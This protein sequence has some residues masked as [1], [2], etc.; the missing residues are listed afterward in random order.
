MMQSRNY[1]ID[2]LRL[3]LM[4]MVCLL[5]VLGQGGILVASKEGTLNYY[6]FWF[7]EIFAYCAVDGFALIS[8]YTANNKK[9]K[10]EKIV[11]MWFQV[12][13]YSFFITLIFVIFGKYDWTIKNIIK[14]IFPITFN[15][16]WYMSSYFVLF[17]AIPILNKF[18]F[19]IDD[20]TAKKAF[21]LFLF[22]F[23]I[24]GVINDSFQSNRGYSALWLMVLYCIGAL[25][26]KIKLLE[27]KRSIVLIIIWFL[28][29]LST[30]SIHVFLGIHKFTNYISP[31]ILISGLMMVLLFSRM[32][33]KDKIISKLSP[34]VLGVYLLQLNR[35]IWETIIKDAFIFVTKKNIMIGILWVL[36][37]SSILFFLGLFVDWLRSKIA[38]G[39]KIPAISKKIVKIVDKILV[40][41]FVF[42]K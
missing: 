32:K 24:M 41:T 19:E 26:K 9:R 22:I 33:R 16:F 37:I 30:W 23:S 13:F 2:C 28:C 27:Q 40:K 15:Q 10:Y 6:V 3:V 31:T 7:L 14:S 1:G 11:E 34:F 38:K 20:K 18:L 5:H 8:G 39:I 4:Y 35:V 42:L 12:F 29:I 25:A 17:F 36:A 21:L